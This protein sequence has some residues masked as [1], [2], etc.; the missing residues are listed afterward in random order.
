MLS[1]LK[2]LEPVSESLLFASEVLHTVTG[3]DVMFIYSP[4]LKVIIIKLLNKEAAD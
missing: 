2:A 4:I 1:G 3:L